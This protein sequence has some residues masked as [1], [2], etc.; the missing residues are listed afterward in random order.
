MIA[1]LG[2]KFFFSRIPLYG[3]KTE[4]I[5]KTLKAVVK[6][7]ASDFWYVNGYLMVEKTN[8]KEEEILG[9]V[10]EYDERMR[11][12]YCMDYFWTTMSGDI[13]KKMPGSGIKQEDLDLYEIVK[14]YD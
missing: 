6:I 7:T 12:Y 2:G 5:S 11:D 8:T 14:D 13:V 3:G 1:S 4:S 10:E 9:A